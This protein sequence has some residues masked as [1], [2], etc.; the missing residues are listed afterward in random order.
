MLGAGYAGEGPA[1]NVFQSQLAKAEKKLLK[2]PVN[3]HR[4][5]ITNDRVTP[6]PINICEVG[7]DGRVTTYPINICE[8]GT[9][10]TITRPGC[11]CYRPDDWLVGCIG[12]AAT[13]RESCVCSFW[14]EQYN[15]KP[16]MCPILK[17]GVREGLRTC[18]YP[19]L[20]CTE[21]ENSR[22]NSSENNPDQKS[23]TNPPKENEM[24]TVPI[25]P[26]QEN[27]RK[28]RNRIRK[29][30]FA[31]KLP[32][33]IL[34]TV[35][36]AVFSTEVCIK[37]S[38]AVTIICY[39]LFFWMGAQCYDLGEMENYAIT[40]ENKYGEMEKRDKKDEEKIDG[41][42]EKQ[43]L[44]DA[45]VPEL[46]K[47]VEAVRKL[48]PLWLTF[49]STCYLV[50]ATADSLFMEQVDYLENNTEGFK[51]PKSV[52]YSFPDVVSI[53]TGQ[54]SYYLVEQFYDE[55]KEAR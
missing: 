52:F 31:A 47:A 55:K 42:D 2:K 41:K 53:I 33:T 7:T 29:K 37:I 23:E 44:L 38:T 8:E 51:I 1:S 19:E 25:Q 11:T 13:A 16:D 10:G 6:D 35:L 54:V 15:W 27:T 30:L 3:N 45:L 20:S 26:Q 39:N 48:L 40:G 21:T 12:P 43:N 18:C 28:M 17:E 5:T 34:G 24:D 14:R 50:N 46:K 32:G 22:R 4:S 9:N 36:A 49:A